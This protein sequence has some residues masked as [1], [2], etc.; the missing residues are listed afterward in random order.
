[1]VSAL[2]INKFCAVV[3]TIYQSSVRIGELDDIHARLDG[4]IRTIKEKRRDELDERADE[5]E[6]KID[7]GDIVTWKE[8]KSGQ[9]QKFFQTYKGTCEEAYKSFYVLR[10]ESG[11]MR[12]IK[13]IN[14][15]IIIDVERGGKRDG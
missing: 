11:A 2:N 4:I 6:L 7:I 14:N 10:L 12:T 15:Y 8:G 9:G 13:R 1:V 3:D 5:K